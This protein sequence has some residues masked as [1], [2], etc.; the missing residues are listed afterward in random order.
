MIDLTGGL[1]PRAQAKL[2]LQNEQRSWAQYDASIFARLGPTP[3]D[4]CDSRFV[5]ADDAMHEVEI[6]ED[7]CNFFGGSKP[8]E[9]SELVIVSLGFSPIAMNR[10]NERFRVL[11]REGP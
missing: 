7:Q 5:D 6:G 4:A 9:E 10:R 1:E 8:R 11:Y 3:F 2:I